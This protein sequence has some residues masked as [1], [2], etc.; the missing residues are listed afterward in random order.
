ML[1]V[2]ELLVNARVCPAT[3]LVGLLH[4]YARLT[5]R[6]APLAKTAVQAPVLVSVRTACSARLCVEDFAAICVAIVI[7]TLPPFVMRK[8]DDTKLSDGCSAPIAL[9]DFCGTLPAAT[10]IVTVSA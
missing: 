6:V 1:V 9:P 2:I 4:W 8:P 10:L 5:L 3:Q 7:P